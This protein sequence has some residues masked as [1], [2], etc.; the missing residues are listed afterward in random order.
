VD[1]NPRSTGAE[2]PLGIFSGRVDEKGRLK[3]PVDVQ[4]FL[5]SW[6]DGDAAAATLFITCLDLESARIYPIS[7][8]KRNQELMENDTDNPDAADDIA[9]MAKDLGGTCEMD[10]QGRVLI[11]ARTRE[12]LKMESEQVFLDCYKGRVNVQTKEVYE[13]RQERA[14]QNLTD[15]LRRLEQKGLK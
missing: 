12:L 5:G 14:R 4:Q 7:V 9:F 3:L 8:W 2:P 13:R 6:R 15:K 11:P 1:V 10:G